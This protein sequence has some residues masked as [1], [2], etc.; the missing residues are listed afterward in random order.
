VLRLDAKLKAVVLSPVTKELTEH[1]MRRVKGGVARLR[2]SG[3]LL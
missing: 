2:A 3:P 1:A